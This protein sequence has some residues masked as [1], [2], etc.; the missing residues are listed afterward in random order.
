[1][2]CLPSPVICVTITFCTLFIIVSLAEL[3]L[4]I[5]YLNLD[6]LINLLSALRRKKLSKT[7]QR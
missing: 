1:M 2:V 6:M 3:N 4:I 7:G 5:N